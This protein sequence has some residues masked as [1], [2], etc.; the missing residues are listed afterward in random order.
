M[1]EPLHF[2]GEETGQVLMTGDQSKINEL[3]ESLNSLETRI[4]KQDEEINELK[5]MLNM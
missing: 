3:V 5:S 1:I 2:I 4:K